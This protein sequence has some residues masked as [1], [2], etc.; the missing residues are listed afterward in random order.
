MDEE[1]DRRKVGGKLMKSRF[2][3]KESSPT[4][5]TM[6]WETLSDTGAATTIMEGTARKSGS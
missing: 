3:M 5:Y 2:I 4:S 6:K 1:S